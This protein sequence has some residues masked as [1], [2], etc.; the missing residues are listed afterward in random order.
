M[1]ATM[2]MNV[3]WDVALGSLLETVVNFYKTT[4]GKIPEDSHPVL[5]SELACIH[6]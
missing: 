2:K 6:Q 3:F 4:Q 1:V 5:M